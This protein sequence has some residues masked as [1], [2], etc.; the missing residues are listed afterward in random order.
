MICPSCRQNSATE[1]VCSQCRRPM[2]SPGTV[3]MNPPAPPYGQQPTQAM[4]PQPMALAP[5]SQQTQALRP[6]SM[7]PSPY[8]GQQ[9]PPQAAT[10]Q[11]VSLT[12][13]VMEVPV[14]PPP[15]MQTPYHGQTG[16][17]QASLPSLAAQREMF[18]AEGP[19]PGELWEKFLAFAFPILAVVMLTAHYVPGSTL[20]ATLVGLALGGIAAYFVFRE[21]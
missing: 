16:G 7:P 12:G 14:A 8:G 1:N 6:Q 19:E 21:T 3:P 11:R 20:W 9:A 18:Y 10:Q 13:E 5:Y 17:Y 15:P 4:S 2:N